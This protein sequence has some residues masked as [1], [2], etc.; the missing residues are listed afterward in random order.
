[1]FSQKRRFLAYHFKKKKKFYYLKDVKV[2][3]IIEELEA[4]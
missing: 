4:I 2:Q 1:M 3:L